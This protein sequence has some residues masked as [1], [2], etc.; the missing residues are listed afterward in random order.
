MDDAENEEEDRNDIIT[1][2]WWDVIRCGA[3]FCVIS[4]MEQCH[5]AR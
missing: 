4:A 5:D 2:C 1:V 3:T